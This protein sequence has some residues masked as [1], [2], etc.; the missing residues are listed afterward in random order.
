MK[1]QSN[2]TPDLQAAYDVDLKA[3]DAAKD[4]WAQTSLDDRIA[5]LQAVKDN[6]M[7]AADEWVD[8]AGKA[9][10]IPQGSPL[11]GRNG[12]RAPMPSC[13]AATV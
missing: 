9:K 13:P 2:F 12:H 10:G 1:H 3:L 6:L 11:L 5:V 8:A 7:R 4:R